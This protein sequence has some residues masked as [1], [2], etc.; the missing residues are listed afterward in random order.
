VSGRSGALAR[1][2]AAHVRHEADAGRAPHPRHAPGTHTLFRHAAGA[3]RGP[4]RSTTP[5][6]TLV[7]ATRH[8]RA[9]LIQDE[10]VG[11]D[12]A[13]RRVICRHRPPVPVRPARSTSGPL[14]TPRTCRA[15]SEHA[16]PVKL[17]D[18]FLPVQ[19]L[20]ARVLAREGRT[21]VALS[22]PAPA[23]SNSALGRAP[24]ARKVARRVRR[25]RTVVRPRIRRR[26]YP[27]A[28]P[29]RFPLASVPFCRA[30]HRRRHRRACHRG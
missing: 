2:R 19:A 20:V 14:R 8:A 7:R 4:L 21:R 1:E 24:I 13:A 29:A 11:L 25:R 22:A 10:V 27:A 3:H 6:S 30:R 9:R 18:G 28:L 23:V 17:I 5:I 15:R 16:I 12:L 26:R